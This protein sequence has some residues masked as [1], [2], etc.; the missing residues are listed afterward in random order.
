MAQTFFFVCLGEY[1]GRSKYI[2]GAKLAT[3]IHI[4]LDTFQ[5]K[6]MFFSPRTGTKTTRKYALDKGRN[7]VFLG[8]KQLRKTNM[9]NA[10]KIETV[11]FSN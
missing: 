8:G 5:S 4:Y 6:K 11:F 7:K 9:K 10:S 2:T 1:G 3:G